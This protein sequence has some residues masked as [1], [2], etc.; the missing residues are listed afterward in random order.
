MN[1]KKLVSIAMTTY[2]G[3]SYIEK[4]LQSILNQTYNSLEIIICDDCS[5]DS[6]VEI[7]KKYI[8]I[9]T[10][11]QLVKNKK[12]LG[13]KKNFE[14]AISLCTGDYIALS[15]Q[16]DIWKN[17]K[18]EKLLSKIGK[19]DLIHSAVSLIDEKGKIISN[20]WVKKNNFK[21]NFEKLIFGTTVTG[22]TVL[23]K[24]NLLKFFYPIPTGEKY[25][26]WWLALL[27]SKSKGITYLDEVLTLYR[28]HGLQ[29]TGV[30]IETKYF[31]FK[32]IL[33]EIIDKKKSYRY[34]KSQ[35][36]VKRLKSFLEEKVEIFN[37]DE[38]D[39]INDALKYHEDYINNF[40]HLKTFKYCIKYNYYNLC[41]KCL[42]DL[43]G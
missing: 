34:S 6:T 9:D 33:K 24:K 10:R 29:D 18:I 28:Q 30:N 5:N 14:Q 19:H 35:Q 15:D 12:N 1:R 13:F 17:N 7:I 16:D 40:F 4:Q 42:R 23:F 26:D 36:Q 11:I 27:A 31:K 32:R 2:N 21:Y 3:E 39:I 41:I 20:K 8:R 38:V 25:H 37:S 22:C 43:I